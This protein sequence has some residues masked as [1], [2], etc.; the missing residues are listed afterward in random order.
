PRPPALRAPRARPARAADR[1]ATRSSFW[2]DL[3]SPRRAKPVEPPSAHGRTPGRAALGRGVSKNTSRHLGC[4]LYHSLQMFTKKSGELAEEA[5]G[6]E[7]EAPAE[8][9]AAIELLEGELAEAD[10][11]GE[12]ALVVQRAG[13]EDGL[14]ALLEEGQL[15]GTADGRQGAL[16]QLDDDRHALRVEPVLAQVVP[17]VRER[18]VHRAGL[19]DPR[20]GHEGD[21]VDTLEDD[22][23]RGVVHDLPGHGED[24][25][26]HDHA[27][28]RGEVERQE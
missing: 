3:R 21:A 6:G 9:V 2:R 23:P 1:V 17:E 28:L 13:G 20:V 7:T 24:A 26:L 12:D 14:A 16:V 25:D 18:V 4:E 19:G 15:L 27:V 8:I 10:E 22:A 5:V 11:G